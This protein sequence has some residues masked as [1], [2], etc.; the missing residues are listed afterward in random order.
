MK[1][2]VALCLLTTS[3]ATAGT[4]SFTAYAISGA[5]PSV[6]NNTVTVSAS[7]G[8]LSLVLANNSS[9]GR[10]TAFYLESG[11]ALNGITGFIG[12]T[13]LAGATTSFTAGAVAPPAPNNINPGWS[14]NFFAMD[15]DPGPPGNS[16]N[17]G[18]SMR[19]DFAYNSLVFNF[20]ALVDAITAGD[21]RMVQRFQSIGPGENGSAWLATAA[22][23]PLPSAVWAGLAMVAGIGGI[24]A[25]KR[26]QR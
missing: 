14:G 2:V 13:N 21:I 1:A 24:R 7:G 10:M 20:T 3:A 16:L 6:I 17:I 5:D 23:V 9:E 18:E 22:V 15:V 19:L 25:A 4:F 8:V 11:S 26:C 12:I